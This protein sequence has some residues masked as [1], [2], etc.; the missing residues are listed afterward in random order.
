MIL[1]NHDVA[2]S[3][4]NI[5]LREA[6]V[7]DSEFILKLRTNPKKS[8]Y[9]NQ[10]DDDINKQIEYMKRYK[11]ISD[12]WYFIVEDKNNKPL[13]THSVHKQPILCKR[14]ENNNLGIGR[15]I[16]DDSA[17]IYQSIESDFLI[18][19]FAFE[20]LGLELLPMIVHKD[21]ESVLKFHKRWGAEIIGYSEEIKHYLME[22]KKDTFYNSINI[23][24]RYFINKV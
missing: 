1:N 12:E 24:S 21:N 16:M 2:I 8:M 3:G 9:I 13:G 7:E 18:K 23:F 19:K 4:V 5:N 14:W 10:T 15:W 6:N 11:T 22:F 20:T 17:N